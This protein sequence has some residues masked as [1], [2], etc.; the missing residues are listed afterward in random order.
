MLGVEKQIYILPLAPPEQLVERAAQHDVGLAL[1]P[2]ETPNRRVAVTNKI[3][4]YFL[5]GLAIAASDVPGQRGIM[6]R[7]PGAGFLFPSGDANALAAYFRE[8]L[9]NPAKLV[10]AKAGSKRHGENRF[11]WD[12]EK[13]SLIQAVAKVIGKSVKP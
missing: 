7:A 2:G 6:E 12:R 5:A 11:Y 9:H 10:A 4:N 8:W 13:A 1:E 3:L